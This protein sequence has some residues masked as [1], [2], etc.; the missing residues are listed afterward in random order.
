VNTE[1][2]TTAPSS[3]EPMVLRYVGSVGDLMR[4][5]TGS[6]ADNSSASACPNGNRMV[7]GTHGPC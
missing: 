7:G 1:T 4:N 2:M 3:W 6:R 5:S